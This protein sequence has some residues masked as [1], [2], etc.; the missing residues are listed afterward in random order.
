MSKRITYFYDQSVG[1]FEYSTNHP[2]RPLRIKMA[3]ELIVNYRLH[4]KMEMLTPEKATFEDIAAFHANDYVRFLEE[5]SSVKKKSQEIKGKMGKFNFNDDS[6]VFSGVYDFCR[7]TAGGTICSAQKINEGRCDVAINWSGGLHHAKRTEASGF[8]YTNDIVLGILELLKHNKRVMYIDIDVHHGD[9]VEEAFYTSDRVMCVSFHKYGDFYP[10]TGNLMDQGLYRGKGYSVNVPLNAGI[11][12]HSY[13]VLFKKVVGKC[14]DTF[15]PSAIVL[16]SGADSLSGDRLGEFNL[17]L[18]GHS[19]CVKF[20]QTLQ[21]PLVVLGGGGYTIKNVARAWAYETSVICGESIDRKIPFNQY[22]EHYG[23]DY[24]IDVPE[25]TMANK[26]SK[27]DLERIIMS[28]NEN[29]RNVN[30]A[31]SV[32]IKAMPMGLLRDPSDYADESE[33]RDSVVYESLSE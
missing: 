30:L 24:T 3:H 4:K 16:Q 7:L 26:N 29:L 20:L 22:Y 15:Q 17:T 23:P 19:S 14:V 18:E 6:P 28:V 10:G 8:C 12:D 33:D 2:M 13:E 11:D 9:G 5:V 31:P 27:E 1:N 25:S 21:I 32:E